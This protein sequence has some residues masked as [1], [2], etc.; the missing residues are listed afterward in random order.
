M[1][2]TPLNVKNYGTPGTAPLKNI[3]VLLQTVEKLRDRAL[4]LPGLGTYSGPSGFGKSTAA[5][6]VSARLGAYHV[7]MKSHWA[8]KPFLEATLRTMGIPAAKT[9]SA[10]ADQ[11]SE[12]LAASQRPFIIDEFD[13]AVQKEGMIDLVR[14]IYEQSN[15]PIVLIGEENLPQKL[16]KWER[17]DGRIMEWAQALPADIDDA[18]ALNRHYAPNVQIQDDLLNVLVNQA[19]GSVRR[20][21]TNIDRIASF[22]RMDGKK[23]IGLSEWGNQPLYT[24]QP[25]KTRGF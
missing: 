22:A 11:V 17:F 13:Y 4:H 25:P 8:K 14:D 24:A 19:Q 10:M 15:A 2:V 23:T 12:E 1:S 7:E 9:I 16:K 20:I 21:V 3:S 18:H 6:F 5:A